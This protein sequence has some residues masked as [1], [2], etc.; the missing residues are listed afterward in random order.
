MTTR[1]ATPFDAVLFDLDGT[2]IDSVPLILDSFRH[3]FSTCGFPVPDE[4]HLLRGVGTPLSSH[5][6]RYS[7]DAAVVERLIASYRG[8]NLAHH[9][10]RIRA[11]PGIAAML[12]DVLRTGART[13]IV[14][15]KNRQTTERGLRVSGLD[16]LFEAIV[17]SDEVTR[18]KPHPEP[19][20]RALALLG[21]AAPR[22]VFVGDSLHDLHCGRA[23]GVRTA[24]ALWG[25]FTR[26]DLEPGQP[27]H[28]VESPADLC[29]VLGLTP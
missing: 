20:E 2:L 4:A 10:T 3:A 14:T 1:P 22:T 11:F 29:R 28:W 26:Q 19:V 17:P 12:Q 18:P 13:A 24:A 9:D 8:H 16:G 21:V 23:A 6:S 27:D 25:P 15:S 7:D 5:F